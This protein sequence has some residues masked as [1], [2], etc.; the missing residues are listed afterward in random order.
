MTGIGQRISHIKATLPDGVTLVAVSKFHPAEAIME[1]YDAG[2]RVFGESRA[3]E[4]ITKAKTLPG[5][6]EW[7]FIGHLQTNKV[8]SIIPHVKCIHSIDSMRLL[9]L[10]DSESTRIGQCTDILLQL[11]VARE[12]TKFGFSPEEFDLL[13]E[14]RDFDNL[15]GVRIRGV[16]GMASNVED[17]DRIK[18]D[19]KAIRACFDRLK[20]R[21]ADNAACDTVSMGMSHDYHAAIDCGSTMVRIGTTIFGEREY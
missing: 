19:F 21:L 15:A 17:A 2:H 3:N 13:L 6:I 20:K 10:V 9:K 14:S 8:R 1:A 18:D 7:H 11:H 12:E 16:M 4:L 5:D